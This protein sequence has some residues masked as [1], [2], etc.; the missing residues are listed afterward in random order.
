MIEDI[1]IRTIGGFCNSL[2]ALEGYYRHKQIK[3]DPSSFIVRTTE[4]NLWQ[5]QR[6]IWSLWKALEESGN[7]KKCDVCGLEY[8]GETPCCHLVASQENKCK[9]EMVATIYV[10]SYQCQINK[11]YHRGIREIFDS[12]EKAEQ[13]VEKNTK[14]GVTINKNDWD[15]YNLY[16]DSFILK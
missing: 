2:N 3:T 13:Y 6:I 12:R 5:A 4:D 16:I 8:Y 11:V 14:D 7:I 10:V 9:D 15:F 1:H